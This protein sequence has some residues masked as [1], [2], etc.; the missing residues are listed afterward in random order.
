MIKFASN[1]MFV[2][3]LALLVGSFVALIWAAMG[4]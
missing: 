3:V 4:N 2:I 1:L